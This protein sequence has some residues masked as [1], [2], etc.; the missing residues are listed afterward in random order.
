MTPTEYQTLRAQIIASQLERNPSRS[1]IQTAIRNTDKHIMPAMGILPPASSPAPPVIVPGLNS[2]ECAAIGGEECSALCY[3][4]DEAKKA[5]AKADMSRMNYEGAMIDYRERVTE[6]N[7]LQ[8]RI[9]EAEADRDQWRG[10]AE[11]AAIEILALRASLKEAENIADERGRVLEI[12]RNRL[13]NEEERT[14]DLNSDKARLQDEVNRLGGRLT[15]VEAQVQQLE[16]ENVKLGAQCAAKEEMEGKA[17]ALE[18]VL[19]DYKV[20]VKQRDARLAVF[21]AIG[22]EVEEVPAKLSLA[23]TEVID[24]VNGYYGMFNLSTRLRFGCITLLEANAKAKADLAAMTKERDEWKVIAQDWSDAADRGRQP[25]EFYK[26]YGEATVRAI[27]AMMFRAEKERDEA[28][29]ELAAYRRDA[30]LAAGELRIPCPEPGTI[31]SQLLIANTIL[32]K[33]RDALKTH[34][35][36]L[37]ADL[38]N[39]QEAA[40]ILTKERDIAL[41]W[42][43]IALEARA[44]EK[45][46]QLRI[47][48]MA[49]E[50]CHALGINAP[51]EDGAENWAEV[52]G[53]VSQARQ[54][55][56]REAEARY[57]PLVEAARKENVDHSSY[58]QSCQ[59]HLCSALAATERKEGV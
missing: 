24:F 13:K 53:K 25:L 32:R 50:V 3:W 48:Q 51:G 5:E 6:V 15:E 11:K 38:R 29:A 2:A 7:S 17:Q 14:R 49:G 36:G 27:Q 59:C 39:M 52:I 42:E 56:A 23:D 1:N 22:E 31:A 57:A 44:R 40:A 35:S 16:I 10:H 58:G 45:T 41:E 33:E 4:M 30:E 8:D 37:E 28:K 26:G 55:G 34:E 47:V 46:A 19:D 43:P 18:S 12:E 54:D 20:M 21:D 9:K